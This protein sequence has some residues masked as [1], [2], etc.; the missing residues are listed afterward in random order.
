MI[1]VILK[2]F[3]SPD[4]VT[5]FTKGIASVAELI[6]GF[7]KVSTGMPSMS[8]S[9]SIDEALC[10]GWIDGVR[11]R[12]DDTFYS[13]RF[14]PRRKESI[15]SRVNVAKLQKLTTLGRMHPAGVA[16]Y[17]ARRH[18]KTGVFAFEGEQPAKL[19][20]TEVREFKKNPLAWKYFESTSP[21]YRKTITHW[22]VIARRLTTRTRRFEQLVQACA[23]QRRILK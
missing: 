2:R 9:E 3:D 20:P 15:W 13:I 1:E 23:E 11:K 22:V 12:I 8:W 6:V 4:G 5:H 17:K 14:T 18:E 19:S 10:V 7:Y 21:G 16:A